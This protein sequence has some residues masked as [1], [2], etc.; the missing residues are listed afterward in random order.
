[1]HGPTLAGCYPGTTIRLIRGGAPAPGESAPSSPSTTPALSSSAA[2]GAV[3]KPTS[4]A[5]ASPSAEPPLQDW[6]D[7]YNKLEGEYAQWKRLKD[8]GYTPEHLESV[9]RQAYEWDTEI[10]AGKLRR[11]EAPA[12]KQPDL[13]AADPFE[14]WDDLDGRQQAALLRQVLAGDLTNS[15]KSDVE[16]IRTAI[17]TNQKNVNTQQKLFQHAV[18][19]AIQ[20]PGV[21]INEIVNEAM[22]T[23]SL[24]P[25]QLMERALQSRIAPSQNEAK[26]KAEVERRLAEAKAAESKKDIDR[27]MGFGPSRLQP[28]AT[29]TPQERRQQTRLKLLQGVRSILDRKTA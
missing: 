11:A 19:L 18:E 15:F 2:T 6:P 13:P 28:D 12:P 25:E 22:A 27:L 21:P 29:G 5:P 23:A 4:A 17:E 9:V 3:D 7:R 16:Q 8:A 26:I 1:M 24:S 14:K 20:N 10:K